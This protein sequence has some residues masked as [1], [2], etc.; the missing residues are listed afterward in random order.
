MQYRIRKRT[1]TAT[2]IQSYFPEHKDFNWDNWFGISE[3]APYK[4]GGYSTIEQA[5]KVIDSRIIG[6]ERRE[7]I[8]EIITYPIESVYG[9]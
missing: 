3:T 2:G 5:Q 1:M 9:C 4:S 8:D 6:D 7:Y